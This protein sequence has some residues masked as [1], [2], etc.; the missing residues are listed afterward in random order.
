MTTTHDDATSWRDLADQLTPPQIAEIE[1]C[2]R[3]GIPPGLAEPKH[4]LNA[5][6]AMA[7][8][9]L[10]QALCADI[11]LPVEA[12]SGEVYDWEERD[13][14]RFGRMYGISS[15]GLGTT[16]VDVVGVQY[17]DGRIERHVLV[18]EPDDLTAEQARELGAALI[19]AA[20]EIERLQ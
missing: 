18:Y 17:N 20:D 2:E 13:N 12:G 6:R 5:A 19:E 7:Q 9:N 14:D 15:H 8:R 4:H 1:Y 3:E 16:T 10:L 11:A